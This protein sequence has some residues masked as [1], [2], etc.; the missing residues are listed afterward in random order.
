MFDKLESPWNYIGM[1]L[2]FPLLFQN[3]IW[4]FVWAAQDELAISVAKR[5]FLLFQD[6]RLSSPVG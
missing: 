1:A 2:T 5:I 4:A 3:H 6:S